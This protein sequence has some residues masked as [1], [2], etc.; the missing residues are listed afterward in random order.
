MN[1]KIDM[2]TELYEADTLKGKALTYEELQMELAALIKNGQSLDIRYVSS[3]GILI[4]HDSH[5]RYLRI[6]LNR[7]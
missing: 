1:M 3:H 2:Y 5:E 7:Q 6:I 4:G